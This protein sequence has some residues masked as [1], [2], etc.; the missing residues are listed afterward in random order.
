MNQKRSDSNPS[1]AAPPQRPNPRNPLGCSYALVAARLLDL[2]PGEL[3][4]LSWLLAARRRTCVLG[5]ELGEL[6]AATG[7]CGRGR[8]S[9]GAHLESCA[10]IT[11][12][13]PP[14]FLLAQ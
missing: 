12:S 2:P 11:S 4:V 3:L 14:F 8:T 10:W 6:G 7:F 9:A 13:G 5:Y 1:P